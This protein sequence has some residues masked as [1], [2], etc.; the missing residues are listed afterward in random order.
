MK[1]CLL[2][3]LI[4]VSA[5]KRHEFKT[6]K[7]LGFCLRNRA[8]ARE[9][10]LK[11]E[12][13]VVPS[14]ISASQTGLTF[15]LQSSAEALPFLNVNAEYLSND[16]LH[17]TVQELNP[18]RA[19]F[20]GQDE[21]VVNM[22]QVK[23]LK[24]YKIGS[25]SIEWVQDRIRYVLGFSPFSVQG[26]VGEKLVYVVND[27]S[28]MNFER[29]RLREETFKRNGNFIVDATGLNQDFP[30]WEE[31]WRDFTD[32]NPNGPSSIGLD[33]TWMN[34]ENIYG[35]PEHGDSL[36]L[37]DTESS[38]PYRLYNLDVFEYEL[39]ER[40]ALYGS[41]PFMIS[42]Q[43][44]FF[45]NNPSETWV[46]IGTSSS[47]IGWLT[48]DYKT[49]KRTHWFSE[50]GIMN[51][52]LFLAE[53]P[54][55]LVKT[56]TLLTGPPSLP[57]LFAISYHQCRWNYHSQKELLEIEKG[58][59]D[60]NLPVDV[61]WLDIEHTPH[62]QYFTWDYGNFPKPVEMINYLASHGRKLVNIVDPH[63]SKRSGYAVNRIF[64]NKDLYVKTENKEIYEA[65]CWP[66]TSS[67]PDYFLQEARNVWA[68]QFLLENY[69]DTTKDLFIWNDMNEP[70]VFGGPENTMPKTNLH[71]GNVEHREVHNLYGMLMQRS[72]Y[73]GLL[74]RDSN[75]RP[76]V[77]S[78]AFY[79]GTQRYGAIWTGDNMAKWEHMEIS[80][81][82]CLAVSIGGI[83]FCGADIGGFFFNPTAELMERWYQV[84]AF[85]P[86][87]RSHAHIET[88]K[89][90]PW[91]FGTESL[92]VIREAIRGRY[93]ILPYF[94]TL[95]YGHATWGEPIMRPLFM[96]YPD[97]KNVENI[98]K[99]FLLGDALMVNV[100]SRAGQ[101]TAQVYLPQGRWYDFHTLVEV[102]SVGFFSYQLNRNYIP[103]FIRGGSVIFTQDR[104]RRSSSLMKK[105]PYSILISLD[106]Q[107][108][109]AGRIF[110]DDFTSF[111]YKKGEYLTGE[112]TF[113]N[114]KL[115]Y[116]IT[117][118]WNPDNAIEK[119]V[120]LGLKKFPQHISLE[121]GCG[122]E[123]VGFYID[124]EVLTIKLGKPKIAENFT[125]TLI[126]E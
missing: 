14:S 44:G 19:R 102:K 56:F 48:G 16:V 103:V 39:N 106:T 59:E 13:S 38:E 11:V 47:R 63:M 75:Q 22:Q 46:D 79:A 96:Q 27:R 94:Y 50:T 67:W 87:F 70:A 32:S 25:Q 37:Q 36:S 82:M 33:I 58:F 109:A 34:T 28:L 2:T 111:D 49:S 105:D 108:S 69:K 71:M 30:S 6:C 61:F 97:D 23:F 113:T 35:I 115:E 18:L 117:H 125:L 10:T 80:V 62:R 53:N 45:W 40:M 77:L 81:P 65:H 121:S 73:E 3:L 83:S 91:V 15:H 21:F 120:I 92:D 123:N 98:D 54:I 107:G 20:K 99:A 5:V 52:Y 84:A 122:K 26:F 85:T 24:N 4:L 1:I 17:F 100:L 90:E 104:P 116:S 78:R 74:L 42:K 76:F 41:V 88:A 43:G 101:Q 124:N 51:F 114:N 126:Y 95:F 72:T 93:R 118:Q 8:L 31:K 9:S 64:E 55:D 57:P 119:V 110:I 12:Y 86:F 60:H 89:R 112:L 7:D 29:T 68:E 66:G